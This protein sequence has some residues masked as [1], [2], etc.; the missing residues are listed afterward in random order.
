MYIFVHSKIIGIIFRVENCIFNNFA[1]EDEMYNYFLLFFSKTCVLFIFSCNITGQIVFKIFWRRR[2]G[3]VGCVLCDGGGIKAKYGR[4]IRRA[5]IFSAGVVHT[6]LGCRMN[7]DVSL[8]SGK[9]GN[10]FP[11]A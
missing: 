9:T 7:L 6:T 10:F 4:N 5:A 3:G 8:Y 1:V 11:F 2:C